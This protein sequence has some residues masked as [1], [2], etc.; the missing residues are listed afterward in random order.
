MA[1]GSVEN[2]VAILGAGAWGLTLGNLLKENELIVNV[3]EHRESRAKELIKFRR[4][5]KRLPG[6]EIHPE[7][8]IFWN[9]EDVFP[10]DFLVL[11]VPSQKVREV[12]NKIRDFSPKKVIS[13]VKGIELNTKKR[14]SEIVREELGEDVKIA[15]LSGPNIA[16]EVA[17]GLPTASVIASQEMNFRYQARNLFHSQR[18]RVYT[19]H[20]VVG[21]EFGGALKN[22]IAIAC[23]YVD[24]LKLGVNAKGAL[25]TRGLFEIIRLGVKKN[26]EPLTFSGLSGM[27]DLITTCFSSYSR[28]R[29]FG[30]QMAIG[31]NKEEVLEE[32]GMVVEGIPTAFACWEMAVREGVEMPITEVVVKLIEGK[33]NPLTALKELILRSPKD[34]IYF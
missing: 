11:A 19:T 21:V 13:A 24:G 29:Y 7:I 9:I 1:E 15:V 14:V 31:R 6:I 27:G 30:E 22:I 16:I 25:I 17:K 34:E 26:A 33:V 3:W 2:K 12:L 5:E 8:G 32:I 23:G 28:N 10:C 20:D 18:F 4:D